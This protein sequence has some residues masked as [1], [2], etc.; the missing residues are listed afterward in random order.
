MPVVCYPP[1]VF[2]D[3]AVRVGFIQIVFVH[4]SAPFGQEGKDVHEGERLEMHGAV[5]E[6]NH[7]PSRSLRVGVDTDKEWAWFAMLSAHTLEGQVVSGLRLWG[8]LWLGRC[9][10]SLR[11]W[12]LRGWLRLELWLLRSIGDIPR[13]H[14]G[15]P[16]SVVLTALYID[17]YRHVLPQLKGELRDAIP[18]EREANLL[19]IPPS[20]VQDVF[21]LLPRLACLACPLLE[22]KD[23]DDAP[24][25]G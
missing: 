24:R 1:D 4:L 21:L 25:D 6:V 8:W 14:L 7:R 19:W 13:I 3:K 11:H 22:R 23:A 2:H 10:C 17:G 5:G 15:V 20:C 18:E 9:W 16:S 12:W